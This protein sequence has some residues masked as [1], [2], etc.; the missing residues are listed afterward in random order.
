MSDFPEF[1]GFR[2]IA[3]LSREIIITEKIDGTN[4]L[5]Y[6]DEQNNIFAGSRNRWLWGSVEP[7]KMENNHGF[8]AWVKENQTE[9][10]KLG[11]GHHYG[12]WWGKGIQRGYGVEEKRFSLFNVSR[13]SDDSVRPKCCYVVPILGKLEFNTEKIDC[14]LEWL[15]A[16]GSVAVPNFMNPEGIVIYH[17]AGG[18][19]FKKTI[20][21]DDK[22]KDENK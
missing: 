5:I 20:E 11:K 6:I 14:L 7:D 8:A 13:W 19:S 17:T 4:G 16:H 2:K 12:E 9:L 10:L 3:R 21:N 22:G 1:Q 18:V 15:K